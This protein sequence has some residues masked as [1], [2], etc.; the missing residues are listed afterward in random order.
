MVV[1]VQQG[2]M[3]GSVLELAG[4]ETG[5]SRGIGQVVEGMSVDFRNTSA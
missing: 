2:G 4:G 1:C 3:S 5:F